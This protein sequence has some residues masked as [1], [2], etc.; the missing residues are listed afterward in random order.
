M[1]NLTRV[2]LASIRVA[3]AQRRIWLL[4]TLF[5]PVIAILGTAL[6]AA[7]ARRS[8]RRRPVVADTS[9]AAGESP[10]DAVRLNGAQSGNLSG[11][12]PDGGRTP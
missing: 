8:W 2:R 10:S 4:Q 7:I 5:L 6:A 9:G 12:S 11:L 1:D 3:K